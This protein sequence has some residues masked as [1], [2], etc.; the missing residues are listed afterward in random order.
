MINK[1]C[2]ICNKEFQVYESKLKHGKG[3]FCSTKCQYEAKRKHATFKC[4]TC[5]KIFDTTPSENQK[6]CSLKCRDDYRSKTYRRERAFNWKGGR[7][8][9]KYGYI[10]VVVRDHPH[11]L[12]KC[13][14]EYLMEHR[15]V[16]EK[17]LRRYLNSNEH[18]H[19]INGVKTDNR[20][21]NLVI[22]TNSDHK[23]LHR[24]NMG[25]FKYEK[26]SYIHD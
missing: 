8:I 7:T 5:Q 15:L 25:E 10:M 16:M 12:L 22:M 18:V 13:N 3:R 2:A 23:K 17:K 26:G 9:D 24:T 6:T 19:H 11:S 4:L 20:I 14:T 21:E 1:N